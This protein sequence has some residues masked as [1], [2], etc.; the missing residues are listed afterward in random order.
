MGRMAFKAGADGSGA[1]EKITG[2]ESLVTMGAEEV[3]SND[4][5]GV[6]A[7]VMAVVTAFFGEGGVDGAL[8][9]PL[10]LF[11][12]GLLFILGGLNVIIPAVLLRRRHGG[13]AVK[14]GGGDLMHRQGVT[15]TNK[16]G[17]GG[18][19]EYDE[20]EFFHGLSQCVQLCFLFVQKRRLLY[21]LCS[22][23]KRRLEG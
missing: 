11:L 9:D 6:S 4:K 19:Q 16:R 14:D 20:S 18:Q 17:T 1:V 22:R 7:L 12:S 23:I 2:R 5:A 10:L 15:C 13:D 21:F 8:L 3:C